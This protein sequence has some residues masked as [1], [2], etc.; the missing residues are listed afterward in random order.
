MAKLLSYFN[1][2]PIMDPKDFL[3]VAEGKEEGTIINTLGRNIIIIIKVRGCVSMFKL[4][5]HNNFFYFF[6]LNSQKQM[7]SWATIEKLNTKV[8]YDRASDRYVGGFGN[9]YLKCWNEATEDLKKVKKIKT[10]KPIQDILTVN[11]V[12]VVVFTDGSCSALDTIVNNLQSPA[13]YSWPGPVVGHGLKIV[14]VDTIADGESS[15]DAFV[16]LLVEDKDLRS[17]YYYKVPSAEEEAIIAP[18]VGVV[19]LKRDHVKLLNSCV[20][21][22]NSGLVVLS[23]CTFVFT[24]ITC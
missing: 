23:I 10:A 19:H 17:V 13:N 9:N 6:Q 3:G 8:V 11:D 2:C 16:T 18:P 21:L 5:S 20:V 14:K 24:F 7:K 1:L 22:G 12:T 4:Y 15:G